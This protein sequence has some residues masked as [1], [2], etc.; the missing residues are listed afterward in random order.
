MH[1]G[2]VNDNFFNLYLPRGQHCHRNDTFL[3]DAASPLGYPVCDS[4]DLET[5]KL[6]AVLSANIYWRLYFRDIL[7]DNS[8]GVV[9]VLT[10]TADQVF[11]YLIDEKD[12]TYL[13]NE[14]LHYSNYNSLEV[15][16]DVAAFLK[17]SPLIP[18][19]LSF[20]RLDRPV[21]NQ[22]TRC[23]RLGC[24]SCLYNHLLHVP[25][26]RLYCQ[27]TTKLKYGKNRVDK[28][29]AERIITR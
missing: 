28:S 17:W 23:L 22:Q 13:A 15:K 3:S 11:T 16:A 19:C 7:P 9:V 26:R 6:V 10:N 25:R 27:L 29:R 21:R 8:V 12:V 4:F 2:I 1:A 24:G 14:D 5:R 20:R 18:P